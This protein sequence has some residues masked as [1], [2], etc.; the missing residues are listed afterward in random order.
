MG[1][2]FSG[3]SGR[4]VTIAVIDSGVN[5]AHPH[6]GGVEG[7]ARISA[8]G[9]TTSD[10]LDY[11]GHGTA[12][13]GAIREKAPGALLYALKVFDRNLTTS[14]DTIIMAIEWAIE[15]RIRVIN[16]SLGTTNAAHREAFERALKR[17]SHEKII[18]VAPSSMS[19][20]ICLPGSLAQA[21]GV[22]CDWEMARDRFGV[23][24]DGDETIFVA[25]AYPREIPG[26]PRERNLMGIS[27]AVANMT[28]FVARAVEAHPA[29]PLSSLKL[30]LAAAV[31]D[32]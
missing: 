25:S 17:A 22:E 28:G 24:R 30:L 19:G 10:Y 32:Q 29:A 4:G 27:F 13:A 26:V 23:K 8:D 6:V 12:V 2:F 14:I 5:P 18:L 31:S 3:Y 7:G 15:R 11:N 16:L 20:Q 9:A 1:E 21:C